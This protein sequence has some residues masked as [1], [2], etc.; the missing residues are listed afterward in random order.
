MN[1]VEILD[2]TLRDGAQGEGVSFSVEDKLKIIRLLDDAGVDYIEAGNPASSVADRELFAYARERLRLR[3]ARLVA[4]GSTVHPRIEPSEDPA[5]RQLVES[6]AQYVSVVGKAVRSQTMSVLG[7]NPEENLRMIR[8][9]VRYLTGLGLYVFFDAEHFFDG[10]REDPDYAL[11]AL[12][13]AHEAGA[14]A[15]ILCDTNGGSLPGD[16]ARAVGEASRRVPGTLGIHSHN[17]SGLATAVTL[18]AVEAGCLHAQGTVNGYGE[19][20]GNANLCEVLPNLVLKMGR[21][22]LDAGSLPALTGLSRA[23]AE[24]ANVSVSAKAPYVG[25]SAFTHKAG[26]HIDA[27]RKDSGAFEH[28]DPAWV[29]NARRYLM[30]GVGGR[31]AVVE[32]LSGIFPE[33]TKDSPRTLLLL[34]EIKALEDDGYAFEEADASLILRAMDILGVKR[35][36]FE[37]LDFHVVSR[38]PEDDKNAQAYVKVKVGD[39]VEIT[40]DEGDGPVNALDLAVR[41]ALTRFYPSLEQIRLT[42]FK[43]RV[44]GGQGTAARVRV[45]MESTDGRRTW[46]TVGASGNIIEA[47]FIALTDSIEYMLWTGQNAQR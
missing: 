25:R 30:S 16:V 33:L 6:G 19:R 7:V 37:V 27:M 47:S 31:G 17:D 13:E 5:L 26:M 1:R 24:I 28:V 4:F 23:V 10:F 42:D 44:V 21:E 39:R 11:D 43:V 12:T 8:D 20:C 38:K 35:D 15:L 40:A 9:T 34:E 14:A 3:K 45:H 41:K 2:T 18:A 22:C 46:S 32:K 29:G 36:Y